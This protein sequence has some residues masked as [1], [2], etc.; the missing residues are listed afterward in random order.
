VL[1]FLSLKH[2]YM[3][4]V[5]SFLPEMASMPGGGFRA[6]GGKCP[7]DPIL[8]DLFWTHPD[9]RED[10]SDR[11]LYS[12]TVRAENP[13]GAARAVLDRMNRR[14][15][16]AGLPPMPPDVIDGVYPGKPLV[17]V[18]PSRH[19]DEDED[20]DYVT[21][22]TSEEQVTPDSLVPSFFDPA[23]QA[24]WRVA[25]FTRTPAQMA[26]K[27]ITG[28]KAYAAFLSEQDEAMGAADD[29]RAL[30]AIESM[31][32]G[33][34]LTESEDSPYFGASEQEAEEAAIDRVLDWRKKKQEAA[35]QR[36]LRLD[37]GRIQKTKRLRNNT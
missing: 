24:A 4:D 16:V 23:P 17:L 32:V 25:A 18:I 12:A 20:E 37:I 1:D 6:S 14:L 9:A 10:I 30:T 34:A 26:E 11:Y 7:D 15:K 8:E 33:Y 21:V 5:C 19:S 31:G 27:Y 28:T 35:R 22:L 29:D 2:W 36:S 13:L 3:I